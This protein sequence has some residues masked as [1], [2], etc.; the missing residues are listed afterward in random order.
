MLAGMGLFVVFN[1]FGQRFLPSV[2]R[3][4]SKERWWRDASRF[5]GIPAGCTRYV[6]E[7]HAPPGAV[8]S[9]CVGSR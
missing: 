5:P 3:R 2:R 6:G 7:G 4:R 8:L 9:T 1:Y